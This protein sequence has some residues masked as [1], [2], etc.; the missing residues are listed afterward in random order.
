MFVVS[1]AIIAVKASD[2]I[3]AV[4]ASVGVAAIEASDSFAAMIAATPSIQSLQLKPAIP[5]LRRLHM[6]NKN[7]IK[8]TNLTRTWR[9]H[10]FCGNTNAEVS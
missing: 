8:S 2:S 5:S 6:L 1:Y 10:F 4:K 3:A 9:S 7:L